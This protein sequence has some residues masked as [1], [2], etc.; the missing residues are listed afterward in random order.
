MTSW[1]QFRP[2]CDVVELHEMYMKENDVM[3][4][5]PVEEAPLLFRWGNG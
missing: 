4:M 1:W 3:G 2:M 5:R